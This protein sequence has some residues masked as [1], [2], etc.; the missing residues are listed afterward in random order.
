MLTWLLVALGLAG[1]V[2][3]VRRDRRGFLFWVVSNAGLMAVNAGRGDW[4]QASM[5]GVYLLLAVWGW[6]SWQ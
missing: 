1:T 2:L 4:A 5:F 3:N 6:L